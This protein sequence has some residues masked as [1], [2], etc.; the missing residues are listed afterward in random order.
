MGERDDRNTQNDS[1]EE[2]EQALDRH[3]ID[4]YGDMEEN[5]NVTGSTTYE[6]L[7]E[8]GGQEL[9]KH[10]TGGPNEPRSGDQS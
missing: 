6:T 7:P 4:L 2:L 5:R 9:P 10:G 1:E 3:R 8:F